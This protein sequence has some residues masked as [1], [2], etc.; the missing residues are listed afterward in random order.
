VKIKSL[1]N[2]ARFLSATL[3]ILLLSFLSQARSEVADSF[4]LPLDGNWIESRNFARSFINSWCGYHLGDDIPRPAGTPIYAIANGEIK[5]AEVIS[6]LGYALIIEHTLADA[7][8]TK[9]TSSYYHTKRPADGGITHLQGSSV[10]KGDII[11]YVSGLKEDYGSGAHLH[12]GIREGAYEPGV[13]PRTEKWFYTGYSTIYQNGEKQCDS[14]DSTH[15]NIVNN[16]KDSDEFI[17]NLTASSL[18]T[19]GQTVSTTEIDVNVRATPNGDV[20]G[21]QNP[22]TS[23]VVIDGP[24]WNGGYWWW[25]IDFEEGADGWVAENLLQL[26][27]DVPPPSPSNIEGKI[28]GTIS[29]IGKYG[30]YA[31]LNP[32]RDPLQVLGLDIGDAA[33]VTWTFDTEETIQTGFGSKQNFYSFST[34][35]PT[36]QLVINVGEHFWSTDAPIYI[37]TG[38]KEYEV[39]QGDARS[40]VSF[41][42]SEGFAENKYGLIKLIFSAK[43]EL[44]ILENKELPISES[45]FNFG[46]AECQDSS[47]FCYVQI[48]Y[49]V[50]DTENPA[51]YTAGWI[52]TIGLDL[53]TFGLSPRAAPVPE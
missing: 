9:F 52:I 7:S 35:A 46:I 48:Q 44:N 6:G 37:S 2:V 24:V 33:E 51:S 28:S 5:R 23:G 53:S 26:V 4:I 42:G 21:T 18:F 17:A 38:P 10:K 29:S 34:P 25:K 30:D 13:D 49:Y 31:G 27:T 36:N 19:I 1:L 16:W 50:N 47:L 22:D 45:E 11:A 3:A 15:D 8:G 41:S 39:Q 43:N 20:N 12:L 40:F 32:P 14:S